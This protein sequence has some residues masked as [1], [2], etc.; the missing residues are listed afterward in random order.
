MAKPAMLLDWTGEQGHLMSPA[1]QPTTEAA[2]AMQP[3]YE[4]VR[5]HQ[6]DRNVEYSL[7]RLAPMLG[8]KNIVL[9]LVL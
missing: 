4:R 3:D 6:T 1:E 7:H 2:L 5:E 8:E 9:C